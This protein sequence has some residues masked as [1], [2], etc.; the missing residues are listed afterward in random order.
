[1]RKK[2]AGLSKDWSEGEQGGAVAQAN[3]QVLVDLKRLNEDYDQKNGFIFIV[4]ATGKT[5]PE[6]LEILKSRIDNSR[7]EELKNASIEQMKIT[8]IRLNKLVNE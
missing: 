8:R 3:E 5:A 6:M 1:L 4:C 2:F 7:D